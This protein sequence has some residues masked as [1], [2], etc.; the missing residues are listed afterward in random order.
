MN[1]NRPL[2]PAWLAA[3]WHVPCP[4]TH[5]HSITHDYK[6]TVSNTSGVWDVLSFCSPG[7]ALQL[8]FVYIEPN[9]QQARASSHDCETAAS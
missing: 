2:S 3:G 5:G 6:S 1:A 7:T 9:P 4:S 8:F